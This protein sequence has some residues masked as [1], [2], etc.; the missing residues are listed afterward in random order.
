MQSDQNGR[1]AVVTGASRGLGHAVAVALASQG[2]AVALVARGEAGLRETGRIITDAGGCASCHSID[3]QAPEQVAGLKAEVEDTFGLPSILVNAAGVFGPMRSIRDSPPER[4]VETLLI[5]TAGPYLL[6]RA[7]V[8]GMID[9]GW[10]R[11]VNVSS[12][13]SLAT[14]GPLNSAYGTSKAALNHFTRHLAAEIAGSGVTANVI[15][16]GELKTE[17]WEDIRE[18]VASLGPHE[19]AYS[20][21]V[22]LVEQT[23]GDPP[24]K[25]VALI[26]SLLTEQA[27]AVNG[28]F[29]WIEDGI[30]QPIPSWS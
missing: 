24:E 6:C 15:H 28:R 13:A 11:I 22:R 26:L 10:G 25:A 23:G 17:M 19:A 4:W 1:V 16:P 21:W 7:F 20:G 2:A 18:Q 12:A 30:Q 29:L 9:A 5:N 8:G 27:S 3:V 14:P